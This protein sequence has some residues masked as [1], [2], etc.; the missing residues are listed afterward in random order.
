MMNEP[1]PIKKEEP[2]LSIEETMALDKARNDRRIQWVFLALMSAV[3]LSFV[4]P[5]GVFLTRIASGN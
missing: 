4:I 2:L 5:L 1:I 3:I